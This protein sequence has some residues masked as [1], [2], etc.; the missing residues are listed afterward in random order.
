MPHP[1]SAQAPPSPAKRLRLA[2]SLFRT[3]DG[4]PS[5]FLATGRHTSLKDHLRLVKP[6]FAGK[7]EL[8]WLVARTIIMIRRDID[9]ETH[10]S[11]LRHVM[12][13]PRYRDVLLE[14]LNTRWWIAICDTYADH[15]DA[16]EKL[17]AICLTTLVNLVKLSETER[18]ILRDP[19]H[20]DARI[21]GFA[22]DFPHE[23]WDGVTSYLVASGDMPR[24]LFS[25]LERSLAGAPP[26]DVVGRMLLERM[27]T[28]KSGTVLGRLASINP[29]FWRNPST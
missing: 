28:A 16:K 24:N 23:L 2:A 26:F 27:A 21:A 7:P 4:I 6:E 9:T 17:A 11:T 15:G 10:W 12:E 1:T 8:C 20:D 25:R 29:G 14:H 22:E 18:L 3:V 5:G 19:N 13:T